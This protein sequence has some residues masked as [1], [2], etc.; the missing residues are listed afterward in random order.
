MTLQGIINR[1]TQYA[2]WLYYRQWTRWELV[3][4]VAAVLVAMLLARGGRRRLRAAEKHLREHSPIVGI[5][6]A[7]HRRR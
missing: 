3:G 4:I 6:L 1:L 7:H 5:G 2:S